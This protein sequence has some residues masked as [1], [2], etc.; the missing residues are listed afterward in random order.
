MLQN[1]E[2]EIFSD[3]ISDDSR[4]TFTICIVHQKQSHCYYHTAPRR[5]HTSRTQSQKLILRSHHP[6]RP[7]FLL[8]EAGASAATAPDD[9]DV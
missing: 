3:R 4:K 7:R 5:I 9:V 8:H 2:D 6:L 1:L